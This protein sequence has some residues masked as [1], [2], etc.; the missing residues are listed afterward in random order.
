MWR[1]LFGGGSKDPQSDA[2]RRA[3]GQSAAD[4]AS[5][6]RAGAEEED[7][8]LDAIPFEDDEL[9][10][11][12]DEAEAEAHVHAGLARDPEHPDAVPPAGGAAPDT[13]AA[14]PGPRVQLH[15][16]GPFV[17][18]AEEISPYEDRP[19]MAREEYEMLVAD[20]PMPRKKHMREFAE[21]VAGAK[22]WHEHLPLL[23][24]GAPF[25]FYLNPF[26]GTDRVLLEDGRA[27]F[28]PRG[29][30]AD[31]FHYSW[32]PTEEYHRRFGFLAFA[33]A[34]ASRF[35]KPVRLEVDD[36]TVDGVLDNNVNYAVLWVPRKPFNLP[37]AILKA[38]TCIVTGVVHPRAACPSAWQKTLATVKSNHA[39]PAETG[40]AATLARIRA[41]VE[42]AGAVDTIDPELQ[43]LLAPE[44]ERLLGEMVAA[45][46][47]MVGQLHGS[48]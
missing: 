13:A 40:G 12:D 8:D 35:V 28:I 3:P 11:F 17:K 29:E 45:M 16:A 22:S 2:K 46:S 21:Y 23:P 10:E 9:P 6:P 31:P 44:R 26:A 19:A 30:D 36:A 5:G 1:R 41:R 42:A 34:D 33:C 37:D 20:L 18:H 4:A 32:M 39:W 27:A 47:R 7:E 48:L 43:E 25:R 38:G 24:T 15:D 14:T